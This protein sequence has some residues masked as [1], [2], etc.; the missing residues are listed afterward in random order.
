M[1]KALI[2]VFNKEKIETLAGFLSEKG[3]EIYA[4]KGTKKYL[5]EKGIEAFG[6]E[7]MGIDT[8]GIAG[9]RIKT[10]HPLLL[11][12]ILSKEGD[13]FEVVV[14]NLYPFE[15][16]LREG[17]NEPEIY[18]YIDIGG[19]T[20]IRAACKNIERTLPIVDPDDYDLFKEK[21]E[22]GLNKKDRFYFA[23]KA[24]EYVTFYDAIISDFFRKKSGDFPFYFNISGKKIFDLRYGENP[25]QKA[26][27]Y[28]RKFIESLYG[29]K[30]SYNNLLDI[31]SAFLCVSEFEEP[32]CVIIKHT[33][34]CGVAS[35]ET[36]E[37]AFERAFL[38]D[39]ESAF[40]GIVAFNKTLDDRTA[41]R[42]VSNFFEV[43]IAPDFEEN[44]VEILK[45]RKNLR[46]INSSDIHVSDYE[47]RSVFDFILFQER[48][49]E[50]ISP[51]E[52]ELKTT[53]EA[54]SA[55][56]EDLYFALKVV[57]YVKSNAI[58]IVKAKRTLGI[59]SGQPS[60]IRA[61]EIAIDKAKSFGLS[62]VG[63][64]LASDAFF[65]FRDSIDKAAQEGISAIVTPGGSIRDEEVI[66]AAEENGIS[67]Y[68]IK[69]RYFRH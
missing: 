9:G 50:T 51:S 57:K 58:C 52:W 35:G 18:E 54:S 7:E 6:L 33:S 16:K 34:P 41:E 48:M 13:V 63:A 30:L 47:F 29:K 20:L 4:T 45:K 49:R 59:G 32:T 12:K 19:V 8:E 66:K 61:L 44:T 42:V 65:P 53:K 31:E 56:I 67:L 22:K 21:Y 14:C 15:E 68:L 39:P 40:G 25:Q 10:M 43:V 69:E 46:I 55:E 64:V 26:V 62:T 3:F 24:F 2:S 27:V 1:K 23:A 11:E 28:G 38:S 60:R 17:I 5:T 36:L 37:E